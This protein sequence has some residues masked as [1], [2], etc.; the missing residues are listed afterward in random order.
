M[1]GYMGRV[2]RM[3]IAEFRDHMFERVEHVQV[4]AR[5]KIGSRQR[6]CRMQDEQVADACS[7]FTVAE[8]R[9]D[10]VGDV[11]NFAFFASF[12]D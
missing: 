9:F 12:D 11:E 3:A 8:R 10:F 2:V 5:I 1:V 4:G 7:C 6:S